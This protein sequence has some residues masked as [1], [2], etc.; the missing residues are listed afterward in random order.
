MLFNIKDRL[1]AIRLKRDEKEIKIGFLITGVIIFILLANV[2]YL[3]LAIFKKEPQ[4]NSTQKSQ[5]SPFPLPSSTT[6]ATSAP[7]VIKS[8]N[9]QSVSGI[10]DYFIPLGSGSTQAIDWIDVLGAQATVDLGQYQNIKEIRFE[11]SV[12]VPTANESVSIRIFNVTDK[13]PVWNSEVTMSGGS[14]A[15]LT[16]SP[17]IYDVGLKLYQ[18]QM[19]TQL[20]A[21]ANLTQSR[22]HVVLQ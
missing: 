12:A 11:A 8:P 13:H 6:S 18:V 16:S 7:A 5:V 14:S 10:K 1:I 19:K 22:I 15:Y 4:I 17:V 9:P 20:Q 3:N 2:I 21:P